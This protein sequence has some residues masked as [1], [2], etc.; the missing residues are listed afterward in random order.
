M[1]PL[2]FD[3]RPK[4]KRGDTLDI[5]M[6]WIENG[7]PLDLSVLDDIHVRLFN[8]N[9]DIFL[10]KLSDEDI[11][12]STHEDSDADSN[13]MLSFTVSSETMNV[14]TGA[15]FFEV[16]FYFEN[17]T[18]KTYVSNGATITGDGESASD[19]NWVITITDSTGTATGQQSTTA[20]AQM[21]AYASNFN[22]AGIS[23]GDAG[24]IERIKEDESGWEN[25]PASELLGIV[26]AVDLGIVAGVEE[27]QAVKINAE[28]DKLS[29]GNKHSI[30][31]FN[32]GRYYLNDSIRIPDNATIWGQGVDTEFYL[33][34]E[35]D[36]NVI[37]NKD[38]TEGNKNIYL[39]D[40]SMHGNAA[41]QSGGSGEGTS[42]IRLSKVT[43]A[44]LTN[45]TGKRFRAHGIELR[46]DCHDIHH[47]GCHMSFCGD[48]GYTCHFSTSIHYT[49]CEATD[50][51][52]IISS[53]SNGL[54]IDDGCNEVVVTN[55]FARRCGNGVEVK[56]HPDEPSPKHVTMTNVQVYSC[57]EYG[58]DIGGS[59]GIDRGEHVT[60]SDVIVVDCLYAL[61]INKYD[62]VTINNFHSDGDDDDTEESI[63]LMDCKH[64]TIDDFEFKNGTATN[65]MIFLDGREGDGIKNLTL[66]NGTLTGATAKR[67]INARGDKDEGNYIDQLTVDNVHIEGMQEEGFFTFDGMR[68][69]K[70]INCTIRANS[71]KT[72]NEYDQV[73]FAHAEDCMIS[74]NII[75]KGDED[76]KP[77]YGITI[78]DNCKD[79]MI[80]GNDLKNAGETDIFSDEGVDTVISNNK[81]YVQQ[82]SGTAII[83]EDDASVTV[84]HN[85]GVAP[86]SI[87]VTPQGGASAAVALR[88]N[89]ITSSTFA[90]AHPS[91]AA[92]DLTVSWMAMR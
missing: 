64:V 48:D 66:S 91:T 38:F 35:S 25:V 90:I 24:K 22:R 23:E 2:Q 37:R 69:S 55:F 86:S 60:M 6:Q 8:K 89:G 12:I 92:V 34:D 57:T 3:E 71:Q 61:R 42:G 21:I 19:T 54:E 88:V 80:T 27:D 81:G 53:N 41:E 9:K 44:R 43:H 65:G 67:G 74:G 15:Y 11:I 51:Q 78:A 5:S 1:I 83:L 50:G 32:K 29:A 84:D 85:M 26:S 46:T 13:D 52:A 82:T 30:I 36:V 33:M 72:D 77:K 20:L 49:D 70:L 58:I 14:A 62:H 10:Q 56:G 18:K 17:G 75:K 39:S 45:I 87:I 79:I 16:V 4:F 7:A 73:F 76:N 40:F 59:G 28:L 68:E 63:R 31:I 47:T